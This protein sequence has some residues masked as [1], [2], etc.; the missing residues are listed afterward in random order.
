MKFQVLPDGEGGLDGLFAIYQLKAKT[1]SQGTA[2]KTEQS[3]KRFVELDAHQE[4]KKEVRQFMP[5]S[6]AKSASGEL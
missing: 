4:W 1:P 6:P 3:F 2:I 5:D